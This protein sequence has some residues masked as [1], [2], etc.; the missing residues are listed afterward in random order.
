MILT[1][2]KRILSITTA[3][4]LAMQPTLSYASPIGGQVTAGSATISSSATQTTID[5]TSQRAVIDWNS[6]NVNANETV[7]FVQPSASS[8]TLNRVHDSGTSQIDGQI[9]AN[10]NV[11]LI[12]PNGV[13]FGKDAQ[14]NVAGLLATSG[15]ISNQNFMNGN[16]IFD[17]SGNATATITNNGHITLAE[18]GLVALVAPNVVNNG[19]IQARLGRVVMASGDTYTVDFY[20]DGLIN[21]Q[22]GKDVT[23]QLVANNGSILARGGNVTLTTAAATNVVDN[24]IN[25]T[26]LIEANTSNTGTGSITLN[27]QGGT[28]L[29]SGTLSAAGNGAQQTGGTV[30]VLGSNVGLLSGSTI[31]VS[32]NAGGGTVR[33]GG[34]FHGAGV[35]PTATNTIVQQ[36]ATIHADALST[37]NGGNVAVW[38]DSDTQFE[39]IITARGGKN[40]G[41]GGYVETSSKQV[42]TATGTVDA[43]APKG[44]AGQWLL[45]P[46]DLTIVDGDTGAGSDSNVTGAPNFSTLSDEAILTNTSIEAALNNGTSVTI[47]TTSDGYSKGSYGYG[48]IEVSANITKSA[49]GDAGLT[50]NAVGNIIVD[51]GVQISS[52]AGKMDVNLN[53]DYLNNNY[54]GYVYMG[55][56]AGINANGG[57]ISLAGTNQ[58]VI[59]DSGVVLQTIGN[60]NISLS[61][62]ARYEED[63]LNKSPWGGSDNSGVILYN[64]TLKTDAGNITLSGA[65]SDLQEGNSGIYMDG[66]VLQSNHGNIALTGTAGTGDSSS[67]NNGINIIDSVIQTGGNINITGTGGMGGNGDPNDVAGPPP[68]TGGMQDD[69]VVLSSQYSTNQITATGNGNITITGIGGATQTGISAIGADGIYTYGAQN[70]TSQNGSITINGTGGSSDGTHHGI[71]LSGNA[72]IVSTGTGKITLTGAASSDTADI[73]ANSSGDSSVIN[74]LIGNSTI[75]LVA[76]SVDLPFLAISTPGSVIFEPRT[77][78]TNI[79]VAQG[80]NLV[81]NSTSGLAI[82]NSIL[83]NITAG[84]IIIGSDNSTGTMNVG[85][86][87]WNSNVTFLNGDGSINLNGSTST[88]SGDSILVSTQGKFKNTAGTAALAPGSGGHFTLYTPGPASTTLDSLIYDQLL[89]CFTKGNCS[90]LHKVNENSLIYTSFLLS[91]SLQS[92]FSRNWLPFNQEPSDDHNHALLFVSND[93]VKLLTLGGEA[94]KYWWDAVAQ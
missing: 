50:M 24:L 41:N 88:A 78:S 49:G 4:A 67:G 81:T 3:I 89:V 28:T 75:K 51:S 68:T 79:N 85:S 86:H 31:N 94:H 12:N 92:N 9:L 17:T 65:G 20:G 60:G 76:D 37:G 83:N 48:N 43:S 70:I 38:A 21:L 11:W 63:E 15:N 90:F 16:Y 8:I 56:G 42:L 19:V 23:S 46:N 52:T 55:P 59:L 71:Y 91:S 40:G 33:V 87:F 77:A 61:G 47:A 29:V 72:Q 35:T 32:G 5:Q 7:Q 54:S 82:T 14:V 53:A 62:N 30:Q 57:N 1:K 45:D 44:K 58:A 36:G 13:V 22:V 80:A 39:G 93:M 2:A 84:N 66:A 26:G 34:D 25:M 27:A 18:G 69:G 6:F 73:E 10:G 64:A 74:N